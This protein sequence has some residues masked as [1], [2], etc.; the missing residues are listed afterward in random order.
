MSFIPRDEKKTLLVVGDVMLDEYLYGNSIRLSPEAPVAV[1]S[2]IRSDVLIGGA[3]NVALNL[4]ALGCI[5][6]LYGVVG[7]DDDGRKVVDVLEGLEVDSN[8]L[9]VEQNRCTTRKTRIISGSQQLLRVDHEDVCQLSPEAEATLISR[10]EGE[11]AEASAIILSDYGKGVL[12]DYVVSEI[13]RVAK[14]HD[15]KVFIDPKGTNYEKYAGAFCITPNL[16]EAGEAVG[17]PIKT[18][19]EI[20]EALSVFSSDLAIERPLITLS[21][22]GIGSNFERTFISPAVAKQ[23]FDVTGAGDTVIAALAVAY[24]N[25]NTWADCLDF[26]NHA[27]GVAV[28]RTGAARVSMSDILASYQIAG[29]NEQL[30]IVKSLD[31]LKMIVSG[32]LETRSTIALFEATAFAATPD[33]VTTLRDAKI[34]N[35]Y[36]IILLCQNVSSFEQGQ[37][38][39][40]QTA[41]NDAATVLGALESVDY[42]YLCQDISSSDVIQALGLEEAKCLQ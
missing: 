13:I 1:V 3:G 12:S 38:K 2:N 21:E 31:A 20:F 29:P 35:E 15:I 34:N 14:N 5:A 37:I 33:Q 42:V 17:A 24:I 40:V 23:V 39:G 9:V 6:K 27:A 22:R 10:F 16:K 4:A 7:D 11:V 36:V 41:I 8:F 28:S 25:K 26:A 32:I 18:D 19:D 30:K